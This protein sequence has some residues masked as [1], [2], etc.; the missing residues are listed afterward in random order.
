MK[1]V[2]L[3]TCNGNSQI[4][5]KIRI[6]S[7]SCS[8]GSKNCFLIFFFTSILKICEYIRKVIYRIKLVI[9]TYPI[10]QVRIELS[11]SALFITTDHISHA[12][13]K[14]TTKEHLQTWKPTVSKK[15]ALNTAVSSLPLWRCAKAKIMLRITRF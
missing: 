6:L 2:K 4:L 12:L 13:T 10:L 11:V 7:K 9:M 14:Y 8:P 3:C 5:G 1:A 15:S